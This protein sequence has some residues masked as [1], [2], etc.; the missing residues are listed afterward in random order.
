MEW[1]LITVAIVVMFIL[2]RYLRKK[3]MTTKTGLLI[4][5]LV[6]LGLIVFF[7]IYLI[8]HFTY[9]RFL[10]VAFLAVF[11]CLDYYKRYKKIQMGNQI[12]N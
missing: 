5:F 12:S 1:I 7:I 6:Y 8:N 3:Y 10:L 11:G 4:F 9:I 2:G